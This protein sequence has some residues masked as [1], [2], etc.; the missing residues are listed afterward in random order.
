MLWPRRSA[1]C[2]GGTPAAMSAEAWKWRSDFGV[3]AGSAFAVLTA[4]EVLVSVTCL[5]YSY[6][7]SPPEVKSFV[8]ALY[9]LSVSAGNLL[10]YFVNMAIV[11]PGGQSRLPGAQYYWFFTCLMLLAALVFVPV[12][13]MFRSRSYIAGDDE[14]EP[15]FED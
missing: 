11:L 15:V 1:T 10:T 4:G 12:S 7:Q 8:M 3:I 6:T 14:I 9:L 13:L 5:E 2:C